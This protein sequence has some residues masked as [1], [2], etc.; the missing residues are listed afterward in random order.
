MKTKYLNP[1]VLVAI[2]S[3]LIIPGCS[4]KDQSQMF[5]ENTTTHSIGTRFH[6]E[7][8]IDSSGNPVELDIKRTPITIIDLWHRQCP[9]CIED[10]NALGDVIKDQSDKI[11]VYSI[12]VNQYWFWKPMFASND[13]KI[14]FL[15]DE[16]VNWKQYNLSTADNPRYKNHLSADRMDEIAK[17]FGTNT[18]PVYLVLDSTGKIIARPHSMVAYLKFKESI[19]AAK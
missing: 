19:V 12:S 3:W 11:T 8:I 13:P 9:P 2:L 14:C 1:V 18:Y 10:L 15:K 7:N 16:L 4:V 5:A 17:R 6:L